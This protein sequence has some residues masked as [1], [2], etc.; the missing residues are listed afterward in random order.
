MQDESPAPPPPLVAS[1]LRTEA[2]IRNMLFP[3]AYEGGKRR[4]LG[5]SSG[6]R[7]FIILGSKH[8]GL[9]CGPSVISSADNLPR[10]QIKASVAGE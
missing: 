2:G 10:K 4:K 8:R 5:L 3:L 7:C 6:I 1:A 9:K